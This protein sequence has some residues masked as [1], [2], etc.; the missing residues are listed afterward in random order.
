MGELMGR[1]AQ[2]IGF[3]WF[4]FLFL[5]LATVVCISQAHAHNRSQSFSS[6]TIDGGDVSVIFSVK[7]R[8]VTRLP[9]LEGNLRS[10]DALLIVHLSQTLSVASAGVECEAQQAPESLL[11]ASGYVRAKHV[12]TCTSA[13]PLTLT[14]DS[15]F[16]MASSHTHYANVSDGQATPQQHLFSNDKRTQ[17]LSV[18]NS[19][20]DSFYLAFLQ[21]AELGMEHIFSGVDHIAFLLVLMMILRRFR[22]L[23]WMVSGFTVGHSITLSLAT[24][25][26]INPDA[27]VVEALIGFTIAI[28][29]LEN[30]TLEHQVLEK[31]GRESRSAKQMTTAVVVVLMLLGSVSLLAGRGLSLLSLIGLMV[32]AVAYLPLSESRRAV[33]SLRPFLTLVFGLIHGFGFAGILVEVEI[34]EQQIFSALAG[35]NIGVELGQLI[36]VSGLWVVIHYAKKYI[37]SDYF[38]GFSQVTSSLLLALGCYW[39]VARSF[40]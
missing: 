17:V 39:F 7:A 6:W 1:A 11:A 14:I 37:A 4:L 25:G 40:I 28:V 5:F 9:P 35:F 38:S 34:P 26:V 27:S 19:G 31:K 30:L 3:K 21:Y 16:S 36:I 33:I 20:S 23:V 24:L 12:F 8:E 15:F 13:E 10:L 2:I 29:A 32:F 18:T 22:D